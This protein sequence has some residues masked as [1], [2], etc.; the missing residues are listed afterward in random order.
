MSS[1]A[2][3]A[4]LGED[5]TRIDSGM[6]RPG[7]A[8]LYLLGSE[9]E[10]AL[11]ET[12][13]QHSIPNIM[14]LLSKQ[15]I[16]P[17]QVKYII[18]THVHLDHAGGVGGLM[19]LLP[20]AT[21]LIHPQGA[22]HMID[23]ARL[24]AGASE[25]YGVEK[26]REIY[27]DIIPVDP[28]RV[29][30]MADGSQARLGNRTLVFYDTP[31]HARHHFCVHDL[32]SNGIFTGDTFGLSYPELTTQQGP[33]VFPTT[34][35]VQFDPEA[36][37]A[38]VLRL[39]ASHPQRMYLTHYGVLEEPERFGPV[40]TRQI[41]DYVA[42]TR[43]AASEVAPEQLENHI[44]EKLTEYTWQRARQHGCPQSDAELQAIL[45]MDMRL[46][47]QGLAIWWQSQKS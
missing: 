9:G 39:L 21:L 32:Q 36:L 13:T 10:Y 28:D 20:E 41:D 2:T 4:G 46:N 26:F 18:P 16:S 42:L 35:P 37:K 31:G 3:Y 47:G 22:R 34:T 19:E 45:G 1:F 24:K 14:T 15:G 27:G 12:G 29:Q 30:T 17:Q 5:I 40:L 25:V 23:P 6:I 11:L 44:I 43:Q 7:L 38:S 8:A 33:F